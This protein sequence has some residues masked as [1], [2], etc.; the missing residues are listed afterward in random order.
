MAGPRSGLGGVE[1]PNREAL[2]PP[3]PPQNDSAV[4]RTDIEF[5]LLAWGL[6]RLVRE[7]ML[8]AERLSLN[9]QVLR[10]DPIQVAPEP[11]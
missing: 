1:P 5:A 9:E 6:V 3:H 2:C 4:A 8:E 10:D 11:E 7:D